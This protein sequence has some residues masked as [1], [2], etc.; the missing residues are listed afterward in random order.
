MSFIITLLNL[1]KRREVLEEE[2]VQEEKRNQKDSE[3]MIKI[4][5][6]AL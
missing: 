5:K 1:R 4:I 6:Y 3:E 2:K